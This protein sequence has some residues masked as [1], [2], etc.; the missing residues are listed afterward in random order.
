MLLAAGLPFGLY[1]RTLAPTVYNLDS[2]ELAAAGATLGVAH[3]PGYPLYVLLARA[4]ITAPIGDVG[5]RVNLL[6][7]IFAVITLAFVYLLCVRLTRSR[8]AAVAGTWLVGL[9]YTFWSDAIVA[10][11]YTLDAALLAGMLYF[12]VRSDDT[13]RESDATVGFVLLGLGLANRVTNALAIP[14]I[15][16][17]RAA[18]WRRRPT[19]MVIDVAATLPGVALYAWLPLRSVIGGG[20]RWGSSYANDGTPIPIDL[21]HPRD[22][23]WYVSGRAF[24]PFAHVYSWSEQMEQAGRFGGNTWTGL[25]GAGVLLAVAGF[26]AMSARRPTVAALLLTVAAPQTFFFISYA[27]ADKDTMFANTYVVIAIFAAAG[28]ASTEQSL[29]RVGVPS[30]SG[31]LLAGAALLAGALI[32]TNVGLLDVSDDY[33]ARDQSEQLMAAAEPDALVIGSWT[34]IAPL[35]Y[36]QLVEHRRT[37]LTF[38]HAWRFGWIGPGALVTEALAT[39][40]SVY[41]TNLSG[42]DT[43]GVQTTQ[44]GPWYQLHPRVDFA[45]E[46]DQ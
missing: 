19:R 42:I 4:F 30:A 22:I 7:A 13:R 12:L 43:A 16:I 37:D 36:L 11:I 10:E 17:F 20:Y 40:R 32:Y 41:L 31:V 39:G 46:G 5:Y 9:S 26:I 24:E 1:V 33:R 18:E 2:A 25:L 34:D 21:M 15:I 44:L 27:V 3:P 45:V 8:G 38:V 6:S 14:G 28:Y 35:E 29:R 23:W